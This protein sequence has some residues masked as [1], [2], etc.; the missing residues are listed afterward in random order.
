MHHN[1]LVTYSSMYELT[2]PHI[3][4]PFSHYTIDA[5]SNCSFIVRVKADMK[6]YKSLET[7]AIFY[8]SEPFLKQ[9]ISWVLSWLISFAWA[10]R[11]CADR[12][13]SLNYKM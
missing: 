10:Y 7:A 13:S 11:S 3:G 2:L 1:S 4:A 6:S 12:E 9:G 8:S 5:A